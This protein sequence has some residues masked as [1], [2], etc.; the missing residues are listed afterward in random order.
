[1]NTQQKI[2]KIYKRRDKAHKEILACDIEL[3]EIL[4]ELTAE[5]TYKLKA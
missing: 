4:Q 5:T 3:D 2:N 1:M